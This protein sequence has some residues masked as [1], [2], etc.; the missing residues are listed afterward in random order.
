MKEAPDG[1]RLSRDGPNLH[2]KTKILVLIALCGGLFLP[3]FAM[4]PSPGV[5]PKPSPI[6]T[7]ESSR[8]DIAL[9]AGFSSYR[10]NLGD[11]AGVLICL[12]RT[13]APRLLGTVIADQ[14]RA[15]IVVSDLSTDAPLYSSKVEAKYGSEL[16]FAAFGRLALNQASVYE[17]KLVDNIAA[18]VVPDQSLIDKTK[19]QSVAGSVPAEF[20]D[21]IYVTAV[22]HRM[23][24]YKEFHKVEGEIKAAFSLI[25][26]GGN[27]YTS[28]DLSSTDHYIYVA[29]L[30]AGAMFGNY[31]AVAGIYRRKPP[32]EAA[33]PP[34][35]LPK[36]NP[37]SIKKFSKE[38]QSLAV[39]RL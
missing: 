35:P 12:P 18:T 20:V 39:P 37:E 28:D 26:I 11:L 22:T 27:Y 33:T 13:G 14:N 31:D 15:R 1:A 2:M 38:I 3:G 5:S 19:L 36:L 6:N 9:P 25:N 29:G 16:S 30:S 4:G 21:I 34:S 8:E 23:L 7:P 32:A 10:K 24:T 17:F